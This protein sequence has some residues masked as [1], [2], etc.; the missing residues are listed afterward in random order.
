MA[1]KLHLPTIIF[2]P[3]FFPPAA[4]VLAVVLAAVLCCFH[5]S[6]N[7]SRRRLVAVLG[8]LCGFCVALCSRFP[9]WPAWTNLPVL[10]CLSF[11]LQVHGV[12][13]HREGGQGNKCLVCFFI[14]VY[15]AKT[16]L[17]SFLLKVAMKRF[18]SRDVAKFAVPVRTLGCL[19]LRQNLRL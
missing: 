7:F 4:P 19:L 3:R 12:D 11:L 15:K 5:Q 18:V 17:T 13:P 10:P 6:L 9:A 2:A 1:A 16:A 14:L 8:L